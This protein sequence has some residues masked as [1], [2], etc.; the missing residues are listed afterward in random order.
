MLCF[1]SDPTIRLDSPDLYPPSRNGSPAPTGLYT[2]R[3]TADRSSLHPSRPC[4]TSSTAPSTSPGPAAAPRRFSP[5]N[6]RSSLERFRG[7]SLGA[8]GSSSP[9]LGLESG[10]T[11]DRDLSVEG[12]WARDAVGR[13]LGREG[14]MR[15]LL[16]GYGH[17]PRRDSR[18]RFR[19]TWWCC[20]SFW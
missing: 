19:R 17:G 11:T 2:R 20:G 13:F 5:S 16:G 1:N 4:R 7:R 10:P 14:P 8:R 12:C 3:R 9:G 18:P 6:C 15:R